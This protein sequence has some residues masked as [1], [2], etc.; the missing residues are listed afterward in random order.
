RQ[1]VVGR[2]QFDARPSANLPRVDHRFQMQRLR[3]TWQRGAEPTEVRRLRLASGLFP[4]LIGPL[5]VG[6]AQRYPRIPGEP[7]LRTDDWD[8]HVPHDEA[9]LLVDQAEVRRKQRS[10]LP[11]ALR[12]AEPKRRSRS[13]VVQWELI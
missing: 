11:L 1:R 12:S 3:V 10:L 6:Q 2:L 13:A 4:E 7:L 8:L 5:E 9:M